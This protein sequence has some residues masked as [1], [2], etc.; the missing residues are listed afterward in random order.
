MYTITLFTPCP[1]GPDDV[2]LSREGAL[3]G[4]S[5]Y[6]MCPG[7]QDIT[8]KCDTGTVHPGVDI[9]MVVTSHNLP[10]T[11]AQCDVT[12][13]TFSFSPTTAGD[14]SFSCTAVNTAF[15]SLSA[16]SQLNI[17]VQGNRSL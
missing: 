15:S 17:L 16:Q 8:L 6:M 3:Q 10:L 5:D 1:D 13:C 11:P 14:H 9:S 7:S 12:G 2:T 4:E